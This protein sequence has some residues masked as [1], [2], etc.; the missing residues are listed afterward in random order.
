MCEREGEKESRL[1][2]CKKAG[3]GERERERMEFMLLRWNGRGSVDLWLKR[4]YVRGGHQ[5][6]LI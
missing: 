5:F 2:W 4:R 1:I 3:V 6:F